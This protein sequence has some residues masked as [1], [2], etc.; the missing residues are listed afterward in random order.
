MML[1]SVAVKSKRILVNNSHNGS[2]SST[3]IGGIFR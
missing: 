1:Q 2:T 3:P